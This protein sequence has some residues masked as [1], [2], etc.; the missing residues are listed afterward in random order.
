[1][2][3]MAEN[4]SVNIR[5]KKDMDTE[6]VIRTVKVFQFL[7]PVVDIRMHSR[8]Q[9]IM[10]DKAHNISVTD[11]ARFPGRKTVTPVEKRGKECHRIIF[12]H[13]SA[14]VF[15]VKDMG[16]RAVEE[17]VRSLLPEIVA[18]RIFAD[19]GVL[20]PDLFSDLF[21][22]QIMCTKSRHCRY[23]P[24]SSK[25]CP[26]NY[27]KFVKIIIQQL[28]VVVNSFFNNIL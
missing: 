15:L 18:V 25:C 20:H 4:R 24:S 1:M 23:P 3:E 13:M 9:R 10:P 19:G 2:Q 8:I 12:M 6:C 27:L 22:K 5:F 11:G 14:Q 17:N 21:P 7:C 16:R 28:F 26:V